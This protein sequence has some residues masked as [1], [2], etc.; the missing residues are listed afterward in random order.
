M[1]RAAHAVAAAPRASQLR[2]VTPLGIL[3]AR[4]ATTVDRLEAA[5]VD[6]AL[7]EEVRGAHELAAGM[8]PY[9]RSCTSPESP[10]LRALAHRTLAEDWDGV[11]RAAGQGSALE[12]EM[13]SGHVEGRLLALLVRISGATRVLDIGT[14]TGYSALAMA[15]ALPP[16][17]QVVACEV[18]PRVAADTRRSLDATPVADRVTLE[19]GPAR[20]T[21]GRLAA[22]GRQFDL[23]FIDAD[24][25][26]YVGYLAALLDDG[27]VRPGGLI[28]ADNT[29]LQGEAYLG[30]RTQA[31]AA[32]AAFNR[33]VAQEARVEQVML[34]LR[35][36]VT[37]MRVA[38]ATA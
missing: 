26:G 32:I 29:L 14:F 35:D 2:P 20:A 5:G 1:D 16:G 17:G 18:D 30:A 34:P 12:A 19:V 31:G 15:E 6:G 9:L 21:L 4:L 7:V 3:A 36:G 24:K 27:L 33:A 28:C 22:D 38:D 25:T 23:A 11:R 13:L 10:A 37:I 8:D